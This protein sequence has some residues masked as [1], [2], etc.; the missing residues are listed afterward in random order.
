MRDRKKRS[1][2]V[3]LNASSSGRGLLSHLSPQ[4]TLGSKSAVSM[5]ASQGGGFGAGNMG[6]GGGGVLAALANAGPPPG[7]P[8][9]PPEAGITPPP[10][11]PEGG[12]APPTGPIFPP[13]YFPPP[14]SEPQAPVGGW[15]TQPAPQL[16]DQSVLRGTFVWPTPT[17]RTPTNL[18]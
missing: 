12:I 2:V 13:N 4:S 7:A 15:P 9:G 18:Y 11:S 10:F 5:N 6:G 8:V 16:A 1:N 14:P 17:R 3:K